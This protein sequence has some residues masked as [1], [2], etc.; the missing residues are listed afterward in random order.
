MKRSYILTPAVLAMS[1]VVA[2][3]ALGAS[4]ATLNQCWGDIAAQMGEGGF[5][6]VHSAASS[7][8]NPTPEDPRIGVANQ[9]INIG[10]GEPGVGGNGQHAIT[11]GGLAFHEPTATNPNAFGVLVDKDGN[12]ITS[13]LTCTQ[14]SA[15]PS[16]P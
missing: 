13:D 1:T 9:G 3:A 2:T 10:A 15:T 4:S 16:I 11:V 6:G 5:M 8:F 14:N 12:A 7:P